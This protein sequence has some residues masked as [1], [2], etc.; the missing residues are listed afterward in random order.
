MSEAIERIHDRFVAE[1]TLKSGT[2]YEQLAALV[3]QV[4]DRSALIVHDVKLSGPGKEA[5]HQI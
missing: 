5:E 3:F 4:L 1:E 2:K